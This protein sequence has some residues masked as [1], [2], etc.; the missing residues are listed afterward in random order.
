VKH[1][2]RRHSIRGRGWDR[3][4]GTLAVPGTQTGSHSERRDQ[5][6]RRSS[7]L[8][9]IVY[10]SFNP[11]RR[12]PRRNDDS[13]FHMVDWHSPHLLAVSIAIL[14][15]CVSDAFLTL[16]LL[17]QGATEANPVMAAALYDDVVTFTTL[18]MLLTGLSV[19]V[20]VFLARYR[21]MR[22]VAVQWM[23]YIALLGYLALIGYEFWLLDPKIELLLP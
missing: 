1:S 8:W 23:L 9:S 16:Q 3:A 2:R 13:R 10:G 5:L 18:K 11:R 20:M 21:F 12:A 22:V 15:L 17:S 19:L 7:I 4:P 14:L 6:D